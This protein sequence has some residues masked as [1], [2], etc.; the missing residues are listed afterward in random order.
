MQNTKQLEDTTQI[1]KKENTR[2]N[3]L[4]WESF[5]DSAAASRPCQPNEMTLQT[6]DSGRF[7]ISLTPGSTCVH[8]AD[9]VRRQGAPLEERAAAS[10]PEADRVD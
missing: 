9:D 5:F 1:R 6:P 2:P 4:Q 10:K 8:V 3:I 7:F